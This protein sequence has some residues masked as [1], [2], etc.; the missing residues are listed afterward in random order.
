MLEPV[1]LVIERACHFK[2]KT[3][4]TCGRPKSNPV[5]RKP[6]NGGTCVFKR[7]TLCAS[8]G[9]TK[10]HQDHMGAPPAFRELGSGDQRVYQ[11]VKAQWQQLLTQLLEES[12]LPKGLARV[13]VEGEATFPDTQRRDQGNYRT[14]IEKALG[15]TLTAGGWLDDDDWSRYEFGNLAYR[16]EAGVSRTRLMLFP[17]AVEPPLPQVGDMLALPL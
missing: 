2:A 6:D 13:M 15:D 11:S 3:C 9:Q 8:C 10:A 4:G 14:L 17:A 12:G 5:H 16:H 7:R 1:E